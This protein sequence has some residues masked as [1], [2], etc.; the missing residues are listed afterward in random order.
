MQ[1]SALREKFNFH[2]ASTD[3]IFISGGGVSARCKKV[4][5]FSATSIYQYT[6]YNYPLFH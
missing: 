1:N 5:S 6:I 2:F 3:D 4:L